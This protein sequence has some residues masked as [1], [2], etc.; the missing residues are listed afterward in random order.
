MSFSSN[1][2]NS[3]EQKV[4]KDGSVIVSSRFAQD[5][6]VHSI[7]PRESADIRNS[8]TFHQIDPHFM[9]S[10]II[11]G[12]PNTG[13]ILKDEHSRWKKESESS[14]V[15]NPKTEDCIHL[16]KLGIRMLTKN[17]KITAA[18]K[19]GAQ[20]STRFNS[21]R[22]SYRRAVEVGSRRRYG[23]SGQNSPTYD[24]YQP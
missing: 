19:P 8:F 21:G 14:S 5:F 9:N 3:I 2:G 10:T 15:Y 24:N 22:G 16:G 18:G 1:N 6:W 23:C 20:S 4:L 13:D 7:N 12:D 17:S 11:L